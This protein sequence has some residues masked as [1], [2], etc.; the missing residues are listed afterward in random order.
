MIEVS[1]NIKPVKFPETFNHAPTFTGLKI[2]ERKWVHFYAACVY[3]IT[4]I[5]IFNLRKKDVL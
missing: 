2:Y 1:Y 3:I 5:K 4:M